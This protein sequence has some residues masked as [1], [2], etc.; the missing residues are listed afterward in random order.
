[1]EMR[2]WGWVRAVGVSAAL[3]GPA[4]GAGLEEL[5]FQV[6][7]GFPTLEQTWDAALQAAEGTPA[8][9]AAEEPS[10]GGEIVFPEFGK[11]GWGEEKGLLAKLIQRAK[12]WK[13]KGDESKAQA[14][15]FYKQ[16]QDLK[17]RFENA[18]RRCGFFNGS[19]CS[20][21]APLLESSAESMQ[22]GMHWTREATWAYTVA[23]ELLKIVKGADPDTP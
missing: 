6:F 5:R 3:A 23:V 4:T 13:A 12:E 1:M 2:V 20:E 17:A 14:G 10:A 16:A 22:K 8:P 7:E 21:M 9:L 19:G 15:I 11:D 18:K